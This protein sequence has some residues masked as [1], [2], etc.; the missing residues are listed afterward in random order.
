MKSCPWEIIK[1]RDL[2]GTMWDKLDDTKIK[3]NV[4]KLVE[5]FS[6][7]QPKPKVIEEKKENKIQKASFLESGRARMMNIVLN[8]LKLDPLEITD[9][10]EQ[11][12]TSVLTPDTCELLIPILPTEEEYKKIAEFPGDPLTELESTDQF[13]LTISGVVGFKERM[14]ALVFQAS[15]LERYV[16]YKEDID[17]F[18]RVYDF[19][20]KDK[21][22]KRIMEYIMAYGNYMNGGTFKGGAP[23]FNIDILGKLAD[24]KSKD[25]KINILDYIVERLYDEHKEP[26]LVKT[27]LEKLPE[28]NELKYEAITD[29]S[30]KFTQSFANCKKLKQ[31]IE[32]NQDQLMQ[33]DGSDAFIKSFY[34]DA[35]EKVEEVAKRVEDIDKQYAPVCKF[36][37]ANPKKFEMKNFI[38]TFRKFNTDFQNSEKKYREKQEKLEKEAKKAAKK[39]K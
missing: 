4:D 20:L 9:A 1:P 35:E 27:L 12:N 33:E 24:C 25:N 17:R 37:A 7:P 15:Y 26:E 30:K 23:G 28:F 21:N 14:L 18:F 8:K 39:K 5:L 11:Y 32:K 16:E 2:D 38:E 31:V 34:S 3:I 19:I 13:C 22:F 6:Q 36:L 10:I 29:A